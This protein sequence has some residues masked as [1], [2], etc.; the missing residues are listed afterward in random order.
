MNP[1][2]NRVTVGAAAASATRRSSS[3]SAAT[4]STL[5]AHESM[6]VAGHDSSTA[7]PYAPAAYTAAEDMWTRCPTPAARTASITAA[8]PSTP[9]RRR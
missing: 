4:L 5:Y 3:R 2:R 1:G 6:P 7:R 8:V 9:V